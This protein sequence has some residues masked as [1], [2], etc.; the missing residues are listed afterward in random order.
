MNLGL[1]VRET[2]RGRA[3][4]SPGSASS[5]RR[6]RSAPALGR[7]GAAGRDRVAARDAAAATS[8][9]TSRP[10]SSTRRARASSAR[11]CATWP[12]PGPRSSSPSTR[13]TCSTA[14][15]RGSSSIDAG[16]IVA[17]RPG[18]RRLRRPAARAIGVE[19]PSR[20]R[21][22]PGARRARPRSRR[23]CPGVTRA[24]ARGRRLRLP[25]R[26]A[27][28]RRR[29][30]A[31]GRRRVAIIGQNGR[32]KSTLVR[33]LNGLLRPTEGRV[34]RRRD[35]AGDAVAELARDRRARLPEPGPPD[36]R[37]EGPRGGRVRAAERRPRGGGARRGRPTRRSTRSGWP[38]TP[39]N[40]YDLGYSR[41]KLLALAS[42]LAMGTPVVVL[43]EPTT[44]QD[45]RGRRPRRGDHRR[46]VATAGRSSRSATTCGS[47]PNFRARRRDARRADRARRPAGRSS[48]RP[49]GRRS[50]H[51]PR[52][53]ARGAVGARLGLGSTP[54]EASLVEAL[55]ARR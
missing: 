1:P 45:A 26:D 3:T 18:G 8:S 34:P 52:A 2:S 38:A 17:R 12:R 44:G 25:G 47:S 4:R 23:W 54:T 16:R 55:A 41:R 9:S 6:A 29:R 32:G 35:I 43:D 28:P 27:R 24:R 49:P 42:I 5:P 36:L 11:R 20:I 10:R 48:P 37:G 40:P 33:H 22:A 14:C 30:P 51:L 50:R 53:A 7:P 39:T 15:A 19:P 13:P 46:A 21:L 31:I